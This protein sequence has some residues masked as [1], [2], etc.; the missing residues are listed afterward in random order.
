MWRLPSSCRGAVCQHCGR[1]SNNQREQSR[2]L[3]VE[4]FFST[5]AARFITASF[6]A[7]W[8]VAPAQTQTPDGQPAIQRN[9]ILFVAD[10]LRHDSITPELTPTIFSLRQQGVDFVNSHSIY[11]TFTTPNASVFA[12]GHLLGDTGDFGNGL[13]IGYPI[14]AGSTGGTLTPFI[15]SDM[16]LA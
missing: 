10:G 4:R 8:L 3:G 6:L 12:T 15:E 16:I 7:F 1:T 13:Y 5:I 9:V 14:S 2:R 11:P